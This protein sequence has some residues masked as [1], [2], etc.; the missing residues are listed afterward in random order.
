MRISRD[1]YMLTLARTA[2][3]RSTCL[4]RSV[5]C[6]LADLRGHVLAIAYNGVASGMPHCNQATRRETMRVVGTVK[7]GPVDAEYGHACEGW[8]L[9][10]GQDK[11]EATHA[12]QNAMVQ[13]PRAEE[14]DTAYVTLGPCVACAK[15]LANTGCRRIVCGE[16]TPDPRARD[17]WLK[18]GRTWECSR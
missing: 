6:V 12:E 4:R 8:D 3:L 14:I 1:S 10:M 9:P 15:L 2:A 7:P 17:L 16:D 13:C 5:G 18:L 11:C